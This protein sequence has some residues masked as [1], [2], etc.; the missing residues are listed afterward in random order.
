MEVVVALL[1]LLTLANIGL[2]VAVIR[3]LGR[4]HRVGDGPPRAPQTEVRQRGREGLRRAQLAEHREREHA[5]RDQ[6]TR[7]EQ[8]A[9][10]PQ[11]EIVRQNV[12]R[13]QLT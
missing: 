10:A 5:H 11:R 8:I 1:A 13:P 3:R 12:G 2:T 6:L 9:Q 7:Q 4:D